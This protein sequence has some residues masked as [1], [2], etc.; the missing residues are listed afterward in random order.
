[1]KTKNKQTVSSNSSDDLPPRSSSSEDTGTQFHST[2][3]SDEAEVE[4]VPNTSKII[5][6][7]RTFFK[8]VNKHSPKNNP[9][10]QNPIF[11]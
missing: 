7:K 9:T 6:P 11:T 8:S 10:I 4:R 3:S 5:K 2:S 1:M